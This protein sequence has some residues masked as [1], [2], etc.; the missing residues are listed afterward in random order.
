MAKIVKINTLWIPSW[1]PSKSNLYDGDFIQRRAIAVSNFGKVTVLF[2]TEADVADR[3]IEKCIVNPNLTE[4]IVYYPKV[5]IK[6]NLLRRI[7]KLIKLFFALHIG[8]KKIEKNQPSFNLVQLC[9]IY[10]AG[11]FVLW[12]HFLKKLPFVITEHW[13]GYR[14]ST[15]DY[16]GWFLKKLGKWCVK[17][18]EI[19]IPVT[20]FAGKMMQQYG[21]S[22]KY[23]SLP[24]VVDIGIVSEKKRQNDEKCH[25]IHVSTLKDAQK[26]ITGLLEVIRTIAEIRTDFILEIVGGEPIENLTYFQGKVTKMGL[27]NFVKFSGMISHKAVFR[28]LE[29]A[30]TFVMFS[31][32]EGLP[33][34][35]LE[36]M[37]MGLSIITTEIGDM[38]KWVTSDIGKVIPIGD[39]TALFDALM[40]MMDNFSSFDT[41]IIQNRIVETCSCEVIGQELLAIY[42][43][44]LN[45]KKTESIQ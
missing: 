22:G 14:K 42:K 25:L 34:S 40:F 38:N 36:A 19:I 13:T 26:N 27:D 6:N 43:E 1:Y 16:E 20:D 41:K 23:I 29:N 3:S 18:A 30:D 4:I 24:N 8:W 2:A 17:R 9:V 7:I 35:M 28:K 32:Y 33:C 21:L 15:G 5:T 39:Q 45:D 44:V 11:I 12:L 10:P 31:N 37:A